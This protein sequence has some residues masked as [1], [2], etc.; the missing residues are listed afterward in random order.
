MNKY[1][2]LTQFTKL[3]LNNGTSEH[4]LPHLSIVFVLPQPDPVQGGGRPQAGRG[5]AAKNK[6]LLENQNINKVELR[7]LTFLAGQSQNVINL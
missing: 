7:E 6:E 1:Q 5:Q 3:N 4:I 2:K